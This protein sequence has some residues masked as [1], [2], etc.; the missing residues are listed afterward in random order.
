MKI[1]IKNATV[2]NHDKKFK[3]NV[4]I[5]GEKIAR[6]RAMTSTPIPS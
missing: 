3:A 2:V 4:L 5:D 6:E 1:A